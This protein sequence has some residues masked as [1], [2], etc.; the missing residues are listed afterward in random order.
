M[1]SGD[2][3][4]RLIAPSQPPSL[5]SARRPL[6]V[7]IGLALLGLSVALLVA[8]LKLPFLSYFTATVRAGC[9]PSRTL[10]LF[11]PVE[12]TMRYVRIRLW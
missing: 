12:E 4:G 11:G 3:R 8:P 10:D 2:W 7:A 9:K 1:W 6:R 5:L